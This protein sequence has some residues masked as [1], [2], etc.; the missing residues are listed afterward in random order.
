MH[1]NCSEWSGVSAAT[2][3]STITGMTTTAMARPPAPNCCFARIITSDS[4]RN[5]IQ[6]G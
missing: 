6:G 4:Y 1:G 3:P 5:D 2:I